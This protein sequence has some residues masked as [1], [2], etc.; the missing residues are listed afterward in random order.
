[1]SPLIH[2]SPTGVNQEGVAAKKRVGETIQVPFLNHGRNTLELLLRSAA[3]GL[4]LLAMLACGDSGDAAQQSPTAPPG[5]FSTLPTREAPVVG[6]Q[7]PTIELNTAEPTVTPQPT[8]TPNPTYTPEPTPDRTPTQAPMPTPKPAGTPVPTA[9]EYPTSTPYPTYTPYPTDTPSPASRPTLAPASMTNPTATLHQTGKPQPQGTPGGII[10]ADANIV[11]LADT[12][13]SMEG[14]KITKLQTVI[15]DFVNRVEDPLEYIALIGFD[16][17]VEVEIELQ[18][19]GATGNLWP[20]KVA[21]LRSGGQTAL[22]DAVAYA[23]DLLEDIGSQERAN[24]I[25]VLTDGEDTDSLHSLSSVVSKIEQA[26]VNIILFGLAYGDIGDYD[27]RVLEELAAAGDDRGWASVAT[28]DATNEAFRSLTGW[29][30]DYTGWRPSP[31]PESFASRAVLEAHCH[32]GYTEVTLRDSGT[33]WGVPTRFTAD[34]P[35]GAVTYML[36]GNLKGCSFAD[37]ELDRSS[38]VYVRI[39]ELGRLRGYESK[40]AC[41]KTSR[42]WDSWD[43]LRITHLRFFDQ[44]SPTK[45][46]EY[47]YDLTN[48]KYVE[49]AQ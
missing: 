15:M 42:T 34:S 27:L 24:I 31:S 46:R 44:S 20:C 1:M 17:R 8:P 40:K 39:E 32:I 41:G 2:K 23:V 22:Y 21:N 7:P 19:F 38:K 36:L 25:I 28:P 6:D 18:P 35:V 3:V 48:D 26:P 47:I 29:F 37:R 4:V 5:M 33:V 14:N 43:G 12:S 10:G 30:Q 49:S 9:T 13:E 11:I 16:S 45:F